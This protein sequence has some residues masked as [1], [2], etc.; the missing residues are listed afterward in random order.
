[1]EFLA[2][3]GVDA[4]ENHADVASN[5]GELEIVGVSREHIGSRLPVVAVLGEGGRF[6]PPGFRGHNHSD[7]VSDQ[8]GVPGSENISHGGIVG[9]VGSGDGV[10]LSAVETT[11]AGILALVNCNVGEV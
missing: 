2:T 10:E 9:K 11:K 7:V 6:H 3:R 8:F 1:L 5:V 4:L